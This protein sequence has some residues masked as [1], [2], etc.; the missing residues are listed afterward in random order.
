MREL[1]GQGFHLGVIDPMSALQVAQG[2][3]L[4]VAGAQ[5][6]R[7]PQDPAAFALGPRRAQQGQLLPGKPA[8]KPYGAAGGVRDKRMQVRSGTVD[9]DMK[10]GE[11]DFERATAK[12]TA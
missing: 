5:D 7:Q 2:G 6:L 12:R 9:A 8:G 4:A 1:L 11:M 10:R 3:T